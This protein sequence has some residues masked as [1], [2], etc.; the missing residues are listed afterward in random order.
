MVNSLISMPKNKVASKPKNFLI[1]PSYL[2]TKWSQR[3]VWWLAAA[4]GKACSF[5]FDDVIQLRLIHTCDEVNKTSHFFTSFAPA[6]LITNLE[7]CGLNFS[8]LYWLYACLSLIMKVFWLAYRDVVVKL[9]RCRTVGRIPPKC[10][11]TSNLM[12]LS[13]IWFI[14]VC[15]LKLILY[16]SKP[17]NQMCDWNIRWFCFVLQES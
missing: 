9:T 6:S 17:Q 2:Y 8:L 3:T 7:L 5:M 13:L 10:K 14:F 15:L 16:N 12:W 11:E 4:M 1:A